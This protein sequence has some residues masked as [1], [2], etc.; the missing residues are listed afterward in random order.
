MGRKRNIG[1]DTVAKRSFNEIGQIAVFLN[2]TIT[3]GLQKIRIDTHGDGDLHMRRSGCGERVNG[4]GNAICNTRTHISGVDGRADIAALLGC[5]FFRRER[6]GVTD[7][8]QPEGLAQIV[9]LVLPHIEIGFDMVN[10]MDHL[11]AGGVEIAAFDGGHN[12]L[13]F[14]MAAA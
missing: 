11:M 4:A 7:G 10:M 13:M 1:S 12:I 8:L 2:R 9:A 6:T 14:L 3:N 5:A